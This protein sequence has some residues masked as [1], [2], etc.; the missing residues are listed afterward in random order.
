MSDPLVFD[1]RGPELLKAFNDRVAHFCQSPDTPVVN[2]VATLSRQCLVL[3]L[4]APEDYPYPLYH[5]L[6]PIVVTITEADHANLEAVLARTC[7]EVR[8]WLGEKT[9]IHS[10]QMFDIAPEYR[11]D[12]PIIGFALFIAVVAEIN[13]PDDEEV[14][15]TVTPELGE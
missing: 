12:S 11:K 5:A 13:E 2:V 14:P 8:A 10:I 3:S 1:P 15:G 6:Q 9:P 7:D 4:G